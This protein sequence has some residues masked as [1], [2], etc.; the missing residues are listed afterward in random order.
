MKVEDLKAYKSSLYSGL[1]KDL[2]D[3]EKNFLLSAAAIFTF[4]L[5]FI[6]DIVKISDAHYLFVL[7]IAW[8]FSALSVGLMMYAFLYSVNTSNLLWKV[9]DDFL[10]TKDLLKEGATLSE[11][12]GTII[13]KATNDLLYRSK[14]AL[15]VLRYLAVTLFLIGIIALAF[16]IAINLVLENQRPADTKQTPSH[17][18]I[19]IS[20]NDT[21]EIIS[22]D[23]LFHFQKLANHG[24]ISK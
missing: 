10:I 13:K 18:L 9:V 8:G 14:K 3:F 2:A 4:S 7:F 24:A 17:K 20:H 1:S 11:D 23:T 12:D 15:K 6:K 5:T 19:F 16:F 21:T 22:N